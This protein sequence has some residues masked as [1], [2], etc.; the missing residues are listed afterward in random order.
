MLSGT[1]LPARFLFILAILSFSTTG[2]TLTEKVASG[3][4]GVTAVGASIPS[5]E[6]QQTYYLGVFDPTDQLNPTVYRV[7]LRGQAS[8]I[9]QVKFASGWLP[10][11][12]VDSLGTRIEM[13]DTDG[14]GDRDKIEIVRGKDNEVSNLATGRRLMLFGPEGFR[15][16][17]ADHRLVIAMGSDPQAYFNKVNEAMAVVA[18]ASQ[19][20]PGD[21]EAPQATTVRNELLTLSQFLLDQRGKLD[22]GRQE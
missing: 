1:R 10:S 19:T 8:I 4:I 13:P 11:V 22:A 16:A 18:D 14:N 9:N 6:I 21:L 12:A 3:V 15:E 20:P 5:H 2:C 7:R 17:P